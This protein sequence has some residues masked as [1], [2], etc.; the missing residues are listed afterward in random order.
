MDLA[1]LTHFPSPYQVELFNAIAARGD[2]TLRVYYLHRNHHERR[3]TELDLRH[4]AIFLQEGRNQME[5]AGRDFQT[6]QLGVINYYNESRAQHLMGRRC[7]TGKPWVFW[8][9]RPR[10]H[11]FDRA[12]RL[13]RKFR[14]RALHRSRS[15]I[16]GIGRLAVEAYRHDFGESRA[17]VNIPYYSNLGGFRDTQRA[18]AVG[19]DAE[20]TM[21]YSGSLISR[22]G[23]DL[24]ARVFARL[25]HEGM[26]ARLMIMGSGPLEVSMR[27][28][29]NDCMDRV[30]F[31]GFKDWD[32]LPKIYAEADLLC[33]PSRYDG[34]GMVV[35]EGLSAG[36]PVISTHQTG[37]AMEFVVPGQNG[38]LVPPNNEQALYEAMR[39]AASLTPGRWNEMSRLAQQSVADHTL[40]NGAHRFVQAAEAAIAGWKPPAGAEG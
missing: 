32:S 28:T 40:E 1:V 36:L 27:A 20:W 23:V 26:R 10:I 25:I 33:V 21:L 9:E 7:A 19:V 4:P 6:A 30:E 2:V 5:E 8:G 3:W 37:A 29:L 38:W 13:Y 24:L 16:W 31:V 35:P 14:L 12:S 39:Q 11:R 17:Y 15:P 34:W 22:K 18:R